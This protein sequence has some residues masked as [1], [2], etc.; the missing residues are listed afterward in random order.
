MHPQRSIRSKRLARPA[1]E[2]PQV[3]FTCCRSVATFNPDM[4][5]VAIRGSG[6]GNGSGPAMTYS[7]PPTPPAINERNRCSRALQVEHCFECQRVGLAL[8][9]VLTPTSSRNGC[10]SWY[11]Y[12]N[13]AEDQ[14]SYLLADG[15]Q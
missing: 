2:K 15:G 13:R 7:F 10:P 1:S 12:E 5:K 14:E 9:S 11:R 6:C 4:V 3:T 8:E